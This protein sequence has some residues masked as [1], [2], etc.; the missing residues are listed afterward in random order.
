MNTPWYRPTRVCLAVSG[1]DFGW[2]NGAGKMPPYYPDTLPAVYN[3]GPG[4]PT[5]ICFGYGAKFPRKYQEALFMCDWSYGKLYACHLSPKGATYTGEL[6]EFLT[7]SPLP[8][9]D[10]VINP[11]DRA[12]YFTIGGR[13]TMSGLYRV[14]Y[15][16]SEPTEQSELERQANPAADTRHKLEAYYGKKDPKAVDVAWP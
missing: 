5:G 10:I 13:T 8:L 12:M 4:S 7:G 9:T 11:K 3:V 6:E 14:T 15:V 16:G 2:R 1:S